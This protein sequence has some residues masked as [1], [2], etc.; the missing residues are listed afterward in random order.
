MCRKKV[1][2]DKVIV[3]SDLLSK[4]LLKQ[5]VSKNKKIKY[6]TDFKKYSNWG[7]KFQK[8]FVKKLN[9]IF[10]HVDNCASQI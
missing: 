7:Y 2:N 4:T 8:H 5:Y 1:Q 3:V 6:T 10:L 9:I